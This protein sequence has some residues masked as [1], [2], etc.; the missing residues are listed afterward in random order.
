[1]KPEEHTHL[2]R[3]DFLVT[4]GAAGA[5]VALA[6][7]PALAAE[8]SAADDKK[9]LPK[10]VLGKT[11]VEVPILGIGTA[12]HGVSQP[13]DVA[14]K[15]IHEFLDRGA[16]YLDTAPQFAGYG[17]AQV[18]LG[19]ALKERRKEAF[20]VTK[21]FR[22]RGD[23][24]LKLLQE[25]LKELQTDHADL[26]YAHSLGAD[27]MDLKTVLG[28]G[29]VM[30]ALEK[31]KRDGLT[32]F[33]GI[34][35]HNRP[36]KFLKVLQ[37]Y[38]IDVMMNAVNFVDR[39]TYGFEREVWPEAAKRNIGLVAMKVF[40]GHKERGNP[41]I[42]RGKGSLMPDEHIPPAFRYALSQPNIT[43]AVIGTYDRQEL[44]ANIDMAR[45]FKPLSA[46]ELATLETTGRAL[47]EAKDWKD[48]FGP[49]T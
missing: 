34:S 36:G 4:T 27:E 37:E 30:K 14:V 25:N 24:A 20:L 31:A 47:A 6:G 16:F 38:D 29:G 22:A 11:G 46:D 8:R 1:M 42:P 12:P 9:S 23:D 13:D 43:L 19:Q 48:H 10:R 40:G 35:G 26:V 7:G 32:R 33:I 49:V 45:N 2:S 3:R 39:W 18:Q 15:L 21:C 17:R 41:K 44:L 5:A 28:A